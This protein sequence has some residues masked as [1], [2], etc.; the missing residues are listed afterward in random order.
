M[1]LTPL[2]K[3]DFL[4]SLSLLLVSLPLSAGIAVASGAAPEAGIISAIF[5]ALIFGFFSSSPLAVIGPAAG[6]SV[7]LSSATKVAGDYSLITL[8]VSLAGLFLVIGSAFNVFKFI[9]IFPRSV[10]KGMVA[11]IG[12]ILTLKMIPHVLGYDRTQLFDAEFEHGKYNT[13]TDIL[14]AFD[15]MLPGAIIISL[16]CLGVLFFMEILKKK[17]TID[18]RFSIGIFVVLAG[19][20][21]NLIFQKFWPELY[22]SGPHLLELT[23]TRIRFQPFA[24]SISDWKF[25]LKTG[26]IIASVIIL[27]GFITLDIFQKIDPKHNRVNYR[28]EMFLL[29]I[30]NILMG[31]IGAL[32]FMPVFIR[33][34]A[35]VSFG[36]KTNNSVILHGIWLALTLIFAAIFSF[37]PMAAVSVVLLV[38]GVRLMN[39]KEVKYMIEKGFDHYAPFFITVGFILFFDLV[40]GIAAGF[41]MGLIFTLRS[42]MQRSM[43]LVNDEER[44][45]LKFHKD[46]TFLHRGELKEM[47][48]SIPLEKE[49]LI[50]GTG[51]IFID[52][53]IEE[54]LE[55]FA[56]ECRDRGCR[57]TF[58]K[59]RLAVSPLFKEIV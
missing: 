24:F 34:T 6:L 8:S 10:T 53:E 45:L 40:W 19:V 50:D 32:P 38:L 26:F 49:I 9:N 59:S 48:E 41:V 21:V 51:N 12:L 2:N 5:G 55:D 57:V 52:K 25:I 30:G 4:S 29:G 44:Y 23:S 35:N 11:G 37:I 18:S 15:N 14:I 1:N 28:R 33:S 56:L 22:L 13:F 54:W 7:F 27:E 16:T 36:A 20:A 47:L 58:M 39:F 31:A 46:V 42:S 17:K 3:D 43:V